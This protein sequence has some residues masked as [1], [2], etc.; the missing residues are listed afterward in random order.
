[1]TEAETEQES[2]QEPEPVHDGTL[3]WWAECFPQWRGR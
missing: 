2:E 3:S 1:M